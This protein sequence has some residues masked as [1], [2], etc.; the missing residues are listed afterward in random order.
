MADQTC[1]GRVRLNRAAAA[2]IH[3]DGLVLFHVPS[4]RI[5]A[6]NRT[7][8]RVWQYLEQQLPLDAIAAEISHHYGIDRATAQ[9]DAA[10]FLAE[11]ERNGLAERV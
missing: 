9:E 6:S 2:S 4:G 10:R 1:N 5:F 11:L 8:A 7:G 3:D